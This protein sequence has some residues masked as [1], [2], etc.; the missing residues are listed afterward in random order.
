M[1]NGNE[2]L[3]IEGRRIEVFRLRMCFCMHV[4]LYMCVGMCAC[5]SVP[6]H[7]GVFAYTPSLQIC[8][9]CNFKR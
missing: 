6:S 1:P 4:C 5:D 7:M 8:V 3:Y 9:H 2:C